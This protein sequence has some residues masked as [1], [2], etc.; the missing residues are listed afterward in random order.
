MG[1]TGGVGSG[2]STVAEMMRELGAEVV[3]ADEATHAVYEPGSPGFDAVVREFGEAYVDGG[4]IDRSRLGELVFRDDDA[5]RRLNAIVH[6][7][8]REWMAQ[9]TAEA[10]ERGV[11]VVVQDVPLL[12][13]NGLERLFSS[14]VLVYVPE[15]VQVERLVSGRGF[16]PERARAMIAAQMPIENKR[17]LAHHVINNSG[18]REDT[19][20]Q[21]RAIWKQLASG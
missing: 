9:K 20:T 2:K 12:F 4:R 8:V 14:V 21:V 10:A 18:K 15:D 19:Q 1:L 5:R 16:T 3:D 13:E 6:P 7:L 17:G 11:E